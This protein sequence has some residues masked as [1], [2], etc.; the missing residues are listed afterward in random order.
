MLLVCFL[1]IYAY[2]LWEMVSVFIPWLR[3]RSKRKH[4]SI[5][6][7]QSKEL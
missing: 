2:L 3:R 4:G 7:P 1:L 6:R 5:G